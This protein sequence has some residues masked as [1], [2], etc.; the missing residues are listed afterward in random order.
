VEIGAALV[1]STEPFEGVQPGEGSLDDPALLAKPGAVG[2]AAAGD[3]RSDPAGPQLPAVDAVVI[4]AVGEQLPRTVPGRVAWPADGRHRVEQ[5]QQL[6]D[7]VAVAAGQADGQRD[8]DGVADQ[9]VLGPGPP[10]IDRGGADSIPPLSARTYEPSTT[11]RSRSSSPRAR[12]WS[13]SF[14]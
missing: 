8:A 1:A 10:A 11:Q 3:P 9:V 6:G 14:A 4:A 13:S 5:G 12:S 7:V 2:D